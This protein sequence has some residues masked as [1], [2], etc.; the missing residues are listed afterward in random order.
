MKNIYIFL[1][2]LTAVLLCSCS[3]A[4]AS[5]GPTIRM[6]YL[7]NDIHHLPLWV[8]LEKGYFQKLEVDIQIEGVFKAGPEI[9]SAFAARALDMAYVGESPATTAVANGAAKVL[10]VSQVNTEGSAIVVKKDSQ[11]STLSELKGKTIAVPGHSTV[12]D[13]LL[14]KGLSHKEIPLKD[15]NIIVLKPPEMITAL[16]H[17]QIDAFIAWEP[18]PSQSQTLGIGRNLAT[19]RELWPNHPCCVIV[20]SKKYT[21]NHQDKVKAVVQANI[22]AINFIE[23][24]PEKAAQIALQYTGMR[25]ETITRAMQNVHYTAKLNK[26]G[27]LEYVQFLTKLGYINLSDPEQFVQTFVNS[28]FLNQCTF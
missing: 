17:N 1:L 8:A 22:Q 26:Q 15:L 24:K 25:I 4:A 18:Y 23:Q 16:D 10:A 9:M 13:F 2:M 5:Q 21:K 27:E 11:L 19:S 6:A 28:T 7:Q 14:R 20:A 12:Q 3:Q